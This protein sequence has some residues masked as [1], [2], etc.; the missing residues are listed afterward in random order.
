MP[1]R[2]LRPAVAHRFFAQAVAFS[3]IV[4]TDAAKPM[5]VTW[6]VGFVIAFQSGPG[7]MFLLLL[8]EINPVQCRC[9][10]LVANLSPALVVW[11]LTLLPY[12]CATLVEVCRSASPRSS[13][14]ASASC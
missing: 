1:A 10:A 2:V 13:C 8:S 3:D 14:R 9:V 5:I 12:G 6:M 11:V 4:G 7:T